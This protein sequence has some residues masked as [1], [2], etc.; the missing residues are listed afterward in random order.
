SNLSTIAGGL[1][2]GLATDSTAGGVSGAAA[3]KNAIEANYLHE[4]ESRRFDKELAE[5][6]AK[7]GDCGAVIQKYLDISNKNSAELQEKCSG[8]G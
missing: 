6:K 7:G 5:C 8:G 4:D 1:A 2:A 3:A